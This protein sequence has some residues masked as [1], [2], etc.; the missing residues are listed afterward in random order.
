LGRLSNLRRARLR[1]PRL[2]R[3]RN[4]IPSRVKGLP[5]EYSVSVRKR[6]RVVSHARGSSTGGG[7][8]GPIRVVRCGHAFSGGSLGQT[9]RRGRRLTDGIAQQ[10]RRARRLPCHSYCYVRAWETPRSWGPA[11]SD[12]EIYRIQC[13]RFGLWLWLHPSWWIKVKRKGVFGLTW[14]FAFISFCLLRLPCILS[15]QPR[16]NG[17]RGRREREKAHLSHPRAFASTF[18]LESKI[19]QTY[20]SLCRGGS[21]PPPW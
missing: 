8:R 12:R 17:G 14:L 1:P 9:K 16:A 7:R 11:I 20:R 5:K 3:P 10:S 13:S 18:P 2:V 6:R 4:A 19:C 21:P 15:P